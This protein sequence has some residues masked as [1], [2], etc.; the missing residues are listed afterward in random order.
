MSVLGCCLGPTL[1]R[2]NSE[3]SVGVTMMRESVRVSGL[4]EAAQC[5]YVCVFRVRG[6]TVLG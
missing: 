6:V 5:V 3:A 2:L 1:K 4:C